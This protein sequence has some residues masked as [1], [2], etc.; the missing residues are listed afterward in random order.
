MKASGRVP[1]VSDSDHTRLERSGKLSNE[2]LLELEVLYYNKISAFKAIRDE[3]RKAKERA[4][5]KSSF[6]SRSLWHPEGRILTSFERQ[7]LLGP[8]ASVTFLKRTVYEELH[9]KREIV[10][11]A[12]EFEVSGKTR[13]SFIK[14]K[15]N[16]PRFGRISRILR[17][18]FAGD[19]HVILMVQIYGQHSLDEDTSIPY[20][21]SCV[22]RQLLLTLDDTI[23]RPL[24]VAL[25]SMFCIWFLTN[26]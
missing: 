24:V 1:V 26:N 17:H 23:S 25:D 16:P 4:R 3:Y 22:E 13:N 9:T 18:N 11:S 12:G 15:S 7:L 21:S 19:D 6:P 10:L 14:V 8:H 20:V 2:E 5:R